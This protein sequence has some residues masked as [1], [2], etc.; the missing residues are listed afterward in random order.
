MGLRRFFLFGRTFHGS[1][2]WYFAGFRFVDGTGKRD[3]LELSG[4]GNPGGFVR[5]PA[6]GSAIYGGE[7]SSVRKGYG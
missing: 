7:E 4:A 1:R 3:S 5:S 2:V 6:D